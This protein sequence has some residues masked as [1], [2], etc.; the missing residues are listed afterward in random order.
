MTT[1]LLAVALA[2]QT[3]PRGTTFLDK[4]IV[5]T[6]E[7]S[8]RTFVGEEGAVVS[9]G[10]KIGPWTKVKGDDGDEVW[11]APAPKNADGSTMFFDQLWVGERRAPNARIPNEGYLET[12][13]A[14]QTKLDKPDVHGKKFNEEAWLAPVNADVAAQLAD[15]SR[16]PDAQV[17]VVL[18]WSYALRALVGF[19]PA[20]LKLTCRSND[21]WIRWKGWAKTEWQRQANVPGGA[22]V[23]FMN[24]RS[25]FDAPGEWFLDRAAGKVLYRPLPGERPETLS[26]VAPRYGFSKI[27]EFRGD[28]EKGKF[29]ENV[30]FRNITFAHSSFTLTRPSNGGPCEIDQYQAAQASDGLVQLRGARNCRF[31]NCRIA[32][33]GNYGMRFG[34]GC[35]SNDVVNCTLEDLGAG[36]IWMGEEFG[37]HEMGKPRAGKPIR[38][39]I[40]QPDVP[41]ATAFNLISNCTIRTAGRYDPEGTG[42]A[43]AHVSD[44]RVI[45]CDIY[46]IYYTGIS[47]GW[48]WGFSGSIAQRNEIAYNRIYDLGKGIMSDMGGVYTLGT[49][50]GTRVHDNIVH[51]V[52]S[53]SYGGWA[54]YCD[55]GSEG[56]TMERNL[57]WNTTDGGFNMH[58]GTGCVIRNN[59]FAYNKMSGAVKMSR[60]VVQDI[61]CTLHFVNN[62]VMVREGPLVGRHVRTVGGIWAN[63]LWY[64]ARGIDRALFD[65]LKWADWKDCGKETGSAFADPRF[66]DAEKLDFRLK[67]DSPAFAL[68]FKPWDYSQAGVK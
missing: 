58:Y 39:K 33:T 9:A 25:G 64:D 17:G 13:N 34:S 23:C 50:F 26:A 2:T 1:I 15:L 3:F 55:E 53:Y 65:N 61:P 16:S 20:T 68:G 32:H 60:A 8:G 57:C 59:I 31:E 7:D 44:T 48:T 43:L 5:L 14:V 63:N 49:S 21:E 30:T 62:V 66:V 52:K 67:D 41:T 35:V 27:V 6:P 18:K 51:D 38:R 56:I 36:G 4:P 29:I 40:I 54:L 11:E 42:V 37:N 28:P 19:D 45:H 10:V 47:V 24:V 46:D 12:T 22:L